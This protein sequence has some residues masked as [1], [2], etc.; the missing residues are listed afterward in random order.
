MCAHTEV[1]AESE[2]N[3]VAEFKKSLAYKLAADSQVWE[4]VKVTPKR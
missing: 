2:I 1:K 4:V 3:A